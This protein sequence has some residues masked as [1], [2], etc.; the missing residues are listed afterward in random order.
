[1][2]RCANGKTG[3][4]EKFFRLSNDKSCKTVLQPRFRQRG[5]RAGRYNSVCC[6]IDDGRFGMTADKPARPGGCCKKVARWENNKKLHKNVCRTVC[7]Y[8][9]VGRPARRLC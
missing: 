3:L 6:A 7:E 8:I 4:N 5:F 9:N 2:Q 1:M